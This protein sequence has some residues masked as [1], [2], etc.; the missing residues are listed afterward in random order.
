MVEGARLERVY[1]QSYRGFRSL[2]LRHV[3]DYLKSYSNT[4]LG[5]SRFFDEVS[6]SYLSIN[7]H[8]SCSLVDC[9]VDWMKNAQV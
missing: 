9:V 4:K 8:K 2:S 5:K 7:H 6:P 1:E 3:D